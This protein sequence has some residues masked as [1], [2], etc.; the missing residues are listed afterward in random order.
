MLADGPLP[1]RGNA[2]W[3]RSMRCACDSGLESMKMGMSLEATL[4]Q[5]VQLKAQGEH[6]S[7]EPHIPSESSGCTHATFLAYAAASSR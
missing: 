4:A 3:V 6:S 7:M 5:V 2:A 1:E